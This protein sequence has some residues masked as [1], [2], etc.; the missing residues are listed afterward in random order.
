MLEKRNRWL[1]RGQQ[2]RALILPASWLQFLAAFVLLALLVWRE[3]KIIHDI[4]GR[5]ATCECND[6]TGGF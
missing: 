1:Q 3:K 6:M 4:Y 5:M 2:C